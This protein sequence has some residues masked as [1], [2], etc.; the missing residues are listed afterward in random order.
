MVG[1]NSQGPPPI[2]TTHAR[3]PSS[4]ISRR[5][6][7]G[8]SPPP[9]GGGGPFGASRMVEGEDTA[10]AL[11]ERTAYR[12]LRHRYAAPPPPGGGGLGGA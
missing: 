9:P 10:R 8:A 11:S 6:A 5:V 4:P 7:K 2:A 12:P 1:L 3:S